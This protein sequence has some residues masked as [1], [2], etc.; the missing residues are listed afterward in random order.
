MSQWHL[1]ELALDGVWGV[2]VA[3]RGVRPGGGGRGACP[4]GVGACRG[5]RGPGRGSRVVS[6]AVG[7][8]GGLKIE[9]K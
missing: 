8:D 6:L 2:R 5:R 7:A 1:R 3:V 9:K 4:G